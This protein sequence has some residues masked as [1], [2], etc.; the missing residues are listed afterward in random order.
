M[1]GLEVDWGLTDEVWRLKVRSAICGVG[2]F[3][4]GQANA[5]YQPKVADMIYMRINCVHVNVV[6]KLSA[7]DISQRR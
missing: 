4:G 2:A 5:A 7:R 6:F 1:F 3:K